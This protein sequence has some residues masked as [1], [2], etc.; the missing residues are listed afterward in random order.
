MDSSSN[1][2]SSRE[3]IEASHLEKTGGTV[4][5][6]TPLDDGIAAPQYD[7]QEV[8]KILRKIDWHLLPVLTILYLLAFIGTSYAS[9]I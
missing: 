2:N 4:N 7:E 6:S 1:F 5:Q 3:K 8:K 9:L